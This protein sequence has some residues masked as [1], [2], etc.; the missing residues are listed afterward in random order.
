MIKLEHISPN[1]LTV[2]R[3]V[4]IPLVALFLLINT[5]L[6]RWVALFLYCLAGLTDFFDGYIAR[7]TGQSSALGRFLDPIADKLLV[8][9]III[10]LIIMG[11][12]MD[13]LSAVNA[14]AG[15]IIVLR[16]I[17]VSGLREY[18][19]EIKIS[20]PVSSLAKWKTAFQL[21][22]LGFLIIGS[23]A[24]PKFIPSGDI[25]VFLLWISAIFTI[26]TGQNYLRSGIKHMLNDDRKE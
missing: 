25:G 14:F 19:A 24:S 7:K 10:I 6:S 26:V 13:G 1:Y 18:L 9:T 11:D 8:A 20:V 21:L 22:S 2:I 3:I 4:I 23:E 5:D 15:I 12:R 17:T 16:E